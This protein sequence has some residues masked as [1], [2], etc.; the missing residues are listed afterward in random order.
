MTDAT[1]E[2]K[3]YTIGDILRMISRAELSRETLMKVWKDEYK[4]SAEEIART[5]APWYTRVDILSTILSEDVNQKVA[6]LYACDCA[7]RALAAVGIDEHELNTIL[8]NVRE[9]VNGKEWGTP[10]TPFVRHNV[11]ARAWNER[12]TGK[13]SYDGERALMAVSCA[14]R[15]FTV[16]AVKGAC[17]YLGGLDV[18]D[19]SLAEELVKE[20]LQLIQSSEEYIPDPMNERPRKKV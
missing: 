13:L 6:R 15:A 20:L 16:D 19:D 4:L 11:A 14:L 5:E 7:E 18:S 17:T 2:P 10:A 9:Y 1:T 8:K 12:Y 3:K